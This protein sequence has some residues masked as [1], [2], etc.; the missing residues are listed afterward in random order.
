MSEKTERALPKYVLPLTDRH[1]G[2]LSASAT[3]VDNTALPQGRTTCTQ[4]DSSRQLLHAQASLMARRLL[5]PAG[6]ELRLSLNV[7]H[8]V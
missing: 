2:C 1:G 6:A 3:N 8:L 4:H 5:T 7:V